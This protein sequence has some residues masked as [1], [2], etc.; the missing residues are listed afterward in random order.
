MDTRYLKEFVELSRRL[1]F[2][3]T[4]KALNLSQPSL[5][6]HVKVLERELGTR[7]IERPVAGGQARLTASGRL[8]L[9]T[10]NTVL[11]AL[12]DCEARIAEL[13]HQ[14][15][16]RVL[17]RTPRNEFSR[18]LLP[19]VQR[20]RETHP[21]VEVVL[22]P[23]ID[24]D[25]AAD[26]ESGDVDIA[27][28]GPRNP[29]DGGDDGGVAFAPF[30][31]EHCF[32]WADSSDPVAGDERSVGQLEGRTFVIPANQKRTSWISTYEEFSR[33]CGVRVNVVERYCDSLEDLLMSR[34]A[35]DELVLCG[36]GL[37]SMFAFS[38]RAD[39]VLIDFDP[40]IVLAQTVAYRSDP[41]NP[42][43][44]SLVRYL[45]ARFGE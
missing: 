29:D 17:V 28:Y 34:V 7:I 43:V 36:E 4:A 9:E 22:L 42:A 6:N 19:Y 11:K 31:Q 40:P 13:E 15:Q 44:E 20:Y 25:G 26:V 16:G 1:N 27:F 14:T 41:L 12:G 38:C 39:R 30:M 32:V 2:T 24:T 8:F 5:S 45:R 33:V 3:S 37:S 10:A 18:P 23:W 21:L 35:S